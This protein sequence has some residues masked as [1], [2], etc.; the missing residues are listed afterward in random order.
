MF[1]NEGFKVVGAATGNVANA[2][3]LRFSPFCSAAE[4]GLVFIL[5]DTFKSEHT[6]EL[7]L[8]ELEYMEEGFKSTSKIHDDWT[9][10]VGDCFS[11]L[12]QTKIHK[13]VS[14]PIFNNSQTPYSRMKNTMQ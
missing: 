6:L 2:K 11:Y 3:A 1:V 8:T 13:P 5:K 10:A 14:I 12:Q 9:D 7:F 4:Q